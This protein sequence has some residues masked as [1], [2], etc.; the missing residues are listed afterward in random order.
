[1]TKGIAIEGTGL[2]AREAAGRLA[3]LGVPGEDIQS[4][5]RYILDPGISV[6]KEAMAVCDAVRVHAMHDPTEGG[7]A[8]ALSEMAEANNCGMLIS[9]DAIDVLPL[10]HALCRAATLDP[11]GLLASGALL[12]AVAD[13]DC[14]SALGAIRQEGISAGRIGSLV[15]WQAQPTVPPQNEVMVI[16]EGKHGR[17]PLPHFPQ[18]EV[19]RFLTQPDE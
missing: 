12:I 16:M 13:D 5:A 9:E 4:A 8:T 1:M 3:G 14:E 7:V 2:L 17:R 6:L 15:A 19:A 18:D 11:L 10:T